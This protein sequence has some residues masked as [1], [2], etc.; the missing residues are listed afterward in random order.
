MATMLFFYNFRCYFGFDNGQ[1]VDVLVFVVVV[2]TDNDRH[3]DFLITL[4]IVS[5]SRMVNMLVSQYSLFY[6]GFDNGQ[7]V[8]ALVFV[9]LF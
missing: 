3:V 6:F 5:D 4:C 7:H 9:V 2:G 1:C 8:D